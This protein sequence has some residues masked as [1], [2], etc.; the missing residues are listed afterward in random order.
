[1]EYKSL[2]KIFSIVSSFVPFKDIWAFMGE[3]LSMLLIKRFAFHNMSI[4]ISG[5]SG[6]FC[7]A[8]QRH[9]SVP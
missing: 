2:R 5:V 7:R 3:P 8:K 9:T 4:Q 1:M 6:I